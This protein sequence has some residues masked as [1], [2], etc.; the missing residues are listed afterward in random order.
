MQQLTAKVFMARPAK[1]SA[2]PSTKDMPWEDAIQKVLADADSALPYADIAE[3]I[4]SSGLRLSVGATPAATVASYLSTSLR[5]KG[6]GSPYLRVDRG[7][8][9]L[10]RLT[11]NGPAKP[12]TTKAVIEETIEPGALQAFG[13]FWQ[14]DL[15]IWT[16]K[17]RLLGRQG[18]GAT[19]VNFSDQVGVYLLHDRER[20]IYVGRATDTLFARLKAHT[21]D[22][23]GG[24]WDRFSWFGLRSVDDSG[25]LSDRKVPWSQ[26]VVVE[27]ME[28]LLIESLE[29]PLN[30]RRGDNFSAAEYLQASDPQV[31]GAKRKA[32]LAELTKAAGME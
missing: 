2:K 9:T 18:I 12:K 29:P 30:R 7:I 17:P 31:E 8:Y 22:R 5:D 3:R 16:G 28:A 14:R 1:V 6:K 32:L 24:R 21:S 15:V 13:M 20:V 19:E 25:E 4:V 11:E 23:L 27:T 10:K 26:E